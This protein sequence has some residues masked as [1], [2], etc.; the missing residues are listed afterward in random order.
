[1]HDVVTNPLIP[2]FSLPVKPTVAEAHSSKLMPQVH[3]L[4]D[5]PACELGNKSTTL[6]KGI[7]RLTLRH[8]DCHTLR[9]QNNL[10]DDSAPRQMT[11]V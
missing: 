2:V 10:S 3:P 8:R 7:L 5:L 6:T 11:I 1:M 9:E 4:G